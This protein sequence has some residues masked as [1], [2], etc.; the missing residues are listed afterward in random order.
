MHDLLDEHPSNRPIYKETPIWTGA[1]FG[2][3]FAGAYMIAHNFKQFDHFKQA[4]F[5]WIFAALLAVCSVIAVVI[6]PWIGAYALWILPFLNMAIA[7]AV[8]ENL[9]ERKMI[10]HAKQNGLYKALGETV[11]VSLVGF[12]TFGLPLIVLYVFRLRF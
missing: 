2:G 1:L 10:D 9:Q 7:Y 12:L 8:V 5:T 6:S 11:I 4:R 3:P